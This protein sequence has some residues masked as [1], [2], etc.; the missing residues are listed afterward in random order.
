M[1]SCTES[2]HDSPGA[3]REIRFFFWWSTFLCFVLLLLLVT[4]R[5]TQ[6]YRDLDLCEGCCP[7][8]GQPLALGDQ[9]SPKG[10]HHYWEAVFSKS[11]LPPNGPQETNPTG[12]W[13]P[14]YFF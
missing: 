11:N 1:V 8:T 12:Q 4:G 2:D 14:N 10:L 3:W 9:S 6:G 5:T 7:L 13:G